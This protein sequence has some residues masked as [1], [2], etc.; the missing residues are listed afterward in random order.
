M[1]GHGAHKRGHHGGDAVRVACSVLTISDTRTLEDDTSGRCVVDLLE[2]AGH[3][4]LERRIVKDERA[5]IRWAMHTP[6]R[7]VEAII[8]TGGTGLAPRDVTYEVVRDLLEKEIPG[9]GELFRMLSYEQ[10]GAAAMLSRATAGVSA[11]RLLF[12]LPGSRKGVELAMEKLV[13]P[14]LGH[15]IGLIRA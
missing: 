4:V 12:A 11:G 8:A 3:T 5:Q 13:V 7:G 14:Q 15:L 10:V 2:A 1:G 9:F 6:P